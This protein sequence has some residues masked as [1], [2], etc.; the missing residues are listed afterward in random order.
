LKLVLFSS[1]LFAA[2]LLFQSSVAAQ[3]AHTPVPGG[4]AV[5]ALPANTKSAQFL[6]KP[7]LINGDSEKPIAIVGIAMDQAPGPA[8]LDL[9][10]GAIV[11]DVLEKSYLTERL[12]IQD[13]NKVTP[14]A[15]DYDR[16]NR[17]RQ[18]MMAV[19]E[20]FT[21]DRAINAGSLE[22]ITPVEGRISSPF[23]KRRILNDQPR[24]PH[25][26]LDIAAPE[27]TPIKA[28]AAGIV[29]A[30]GDYF[31]N[32]NTVLIDHGQGLIT[33]YCHLSKIKVELN[34][35]VEQGEVIGLVGQTG[36]VTGPHLHFSVNLN[37]ARVDPALFIAQP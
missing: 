23:G 14:P 7:V 30:T 34:A 13:N 15:R 9:V 4:V 20:S 10:S 24:S 27:G 36:R 5:I 16:I 11:F 18:E 33:M 26:G 3:P 21:T 8:Q 29:R 28:A 32:G 35:T 37:Q 25:S 1:A 19:F 17:D 6:G 22:F 2:L 12:T 31:F